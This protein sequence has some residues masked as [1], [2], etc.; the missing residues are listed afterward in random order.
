MLK[1]KT[2]IEIAGHTAMPDVN[3]FLK[4]VADARP[5]IFDSPSILEDDFKIDSA[6]LNLPFDCCA[7][8]I[9]GGLDLASFRINPDEEIKW[10][11]AYL[12]ALVCMRDGLRTKFVALGRQPPMPEGVLAA[13]SDESPEFTAV[14]RLYLQR[15]N[16]CALGAER[17]NER[18][19]TRVKG[20]KHLIKIREVIHVTPKKI[21][22]VPGPFGGHVDYSHRFEVRGHWRQIERIGKDPHGDYG[23]KG[24]TWVVPSIKGP[25][26]KPLVRKQRVI[27]QT[28][29]PCR[30]PS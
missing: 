3:A 2:L 26:N 16:F 19:K 7:F 6:P 15:L 30:S 21:V 28:S 17:V 24:Y 5:F 8:E 25:K 9:V 22:G 29:E 23:V 12:T 10:T 13:T 4:S 11:R 27:H 18:V 1:L 20:E 14:A